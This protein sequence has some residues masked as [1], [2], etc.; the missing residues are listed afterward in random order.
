ML[1]AHR[2]LAV[3]LLAVLT[4]LPVAATACGGLCTS[5]MQPREVAAQSAHESCHRAAGDMTTRMSTAD[6]RCT[7][8]GDEGGILQSIVPVRESGNTSPLAFSGPRL[9][10]PAAA[11]DAAR[12]LM[13]A[14]APPGGAI[15][16]SIPLVLRV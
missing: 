9:E 4:G 1:W 11:F 7:T 8:H 16:P 5:D 13:P 12:T 3:F 15:T 10:V 14:G 2:Q 6:N